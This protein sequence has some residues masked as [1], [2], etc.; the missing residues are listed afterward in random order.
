MDIG[1]VA[2][3]PPTHQEGSRS[4]NSLR[5]FSSSDRSTNPDATWEICVT[6]G[7]KNSKSSKPQMDQ[8]VKNKNRP[9]RP[10]VST[11]TARPMPPA[12]RVW[13]LSLT[14]IGFTAIAYMP[15]WSGKP[16]WD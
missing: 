14:L 13:F 8:R 10:R 1:N 15:A 11:A 4:A 5:R 3:K 6:L 16:I 2:D 9:K 7:Q 12:Y